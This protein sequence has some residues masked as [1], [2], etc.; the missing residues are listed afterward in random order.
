[1]SD[2]LVS[3]VNSIV[4]HRN[5]VFGQ[6]FYAVLFESEGRRMLATVLNKEADTNIGAINCFVV[7]VDKAA[8]GNVRFGENSYRGDNFADE[9]RAA[10]AEW[11]KQ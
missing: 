6:P 4:Y 7:D 8:E 11:N 5:G 10:I 9:L 1:M 2:K 3:K